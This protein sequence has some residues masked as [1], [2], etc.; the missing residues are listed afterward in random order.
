MA[1]QYCFHSQDLRERTLEAV[2]AF[3]RVHSYHC[4]RRLE[5]TF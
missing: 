4:C 1:V 5:T 2:L 3:G